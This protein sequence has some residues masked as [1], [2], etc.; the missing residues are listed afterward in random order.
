MACGTLII[1]ADSTVAM[2]MGH[3]MRCLALAQSWQDAGGRCCFVIAN[4]AEAL[5]E[6][7][8]SEEMEVEAVSGKTGSKED[9]AELCRIAAGR[10]ATWIVVDGYQFDSEYQRA[11]KEAGF[12]LLVMDDY[13]HAGRY[14]ADIVLNQNL[15]ASEE[16][17]GR[18][19]PYTKLLPGT[20]YVVLRREF[21]RWQSWKR[22]ISVIGRK[23]LV[24]M[25]G[26]DPENLTCEVIEALALAQIPQL[27]V[28][29]LVGSS[30]PHLQSLQSAAARFPGSLRLECAPQDVTTLMAWAD[31]AISAAGSTCW[32]L[33]AMGLPMIVI[34]GIFHQKVI[35]EG[36]QARRCGKHATLAEIAKLGTETAAMLSFQQDREELSRNARE[37][38][39]G[40]GAARVVTEM[41]RPFI[42]LRA[43]Q[44]DDCDLLWN[45]VN[46]P[47]VRAASFS[48]RPIIREDHVRWFEQKLQDT[49]CSIFIAT[50]SG[51]AAFGQVRFEK[52]NKENATIGV[53]ISKE[54]RGRSYSRALLTLS[55]EKAFHDPDLKF[56]HAFIKGEN[57]RSLRAFADAGFTQV[58]TEEM[59][60]VAHFVKER[61]VRQD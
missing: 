28:V 38:V 20:R 60:T 53:S 50:D 15:G 45:W 51:N 12:S 9:C 7:L 36:L 30:N 31:L 44:A 56:I 2:G 32:E 35:A 49:G 14:Y 24:T 57:E 5:L 42:R 16:L 8:R 1:R 29:V 54:N 19:E 4:A 48:S 39:D 59:G 10:D 11:I 37:Q 25:G 23:V 46:D 6:R 34:D 27:E 58:A 43:A 52:I 26:S 21:A 47:E 17:Y 61:I 18:F 3:V 55:V 13:G 41:Q 40:R 22:E 33:C